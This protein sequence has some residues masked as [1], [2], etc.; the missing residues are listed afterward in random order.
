MTNDIIRG[1]ITKVIWNVLELRC[2]VL[3]SFFLQVFLIFFGNRRKYIAN[4]W[5]HVCVWLTYLLADLVATF[6]LGKLS[7]DINPSTDPNF[8][9]WVPFLLVHL[10]GPD[11]ITA[12]GLEDNELWLRHLLGLFSQL[13]VASYVVYSSWNGNNLNYVTIP[14]M[15]VG[16][17]K[18]GERTW[19]LWLGSSKKFRK[20]ILPPP[21]AGPNYAKFMDNYTA[22]EAEGYKVELKGEWES[23]PILLDH[24]PGT[25]AN[26]S[27][28]DALL[29]QDGFYFLE[30]FECLFADLILSIQDHRS[31]QHFFQ[32]RSWEHAYKVIE[33]ELGLMY[34][35]LYTKA[36]VTYS[37][38]LGLVLKFVT[39]SC[40]LFAF[41]A[42]Y[43]LIDKA[44]ID[45]D[46]IITLVLFAGAIF[47]EI[48][49]VIVLL[50]SSQTM[51][52]LSS[53]HK[54]RKVDLL[55]KAIACFQRCF[56]LS[57]T[58][59]W[60]NLMTQFNLISFCLKDEPVK[61]I[62][63]QKFLGVYEFFE[64]SYYQHTHAVQEELKKLIFEQILDKSWDAKDTKACKTLCALRGDRVLH[65]RKCRF[66]DWSTEVEFDQSLLLWHIATD[67]CYYSDKSKSDESDE[68]DEN[69]ML[70]LWH[71]ATDLCCESESDESEANCA[72]W[73]QNYKISK[74]LS[75]YMLYLLVECPFMLPNGIGQIRFEDTCAEASEILQE[76]KYISQ[77][78]KVCQVILRVNTDVLPSKVKGD[79]SKSVLFDAR[80]LA[81]S[82]QSLETKRNWSKE[83][84]WEMISHV[85]VEMLCYAAS[86]CRG[87]HHAK[88]L[89]R[90]GE[91]L[92]HVWLLMAHLGITEQFQISQGHARAK[93]IVS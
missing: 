54:S 50:C 19:S 28:P 46:Q 56:Q 40:T 68:S 51:H 72:A 34:D 75:D 89:S 84:K 42:F 45:Y 66:I 82:L 37:R 36:V 58:K 73:L 79:R 64:K 59:R 85:W 57:H 7:R 12:Y 53:K 44:H 69:C 49:A 41:I 26:E 91:L 80:R 63:V 29:L 43:C 27:V 55:Y 52:W 25:I 10:G 39:F 47:L 31:S 92:T 14:V 65:K 76:R 90:G 15:V 21:D 18:Y 93:L 3:L 35:K 20:S 86:Q 71:I 78:D 60:S 5:L 77:R 38:P 88:Q 30:I 67:L 1:L 9:I 83:E 23:T 8:V 24:P 6:A 70:W 74:F 22:K 33:V 87:L 61:C 16:I 32:N 48:Y 11:T 62:N 17:I 4:T 81:K 13:A 2:V